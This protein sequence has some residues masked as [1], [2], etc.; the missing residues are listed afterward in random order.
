MPWWIS[1]LT[2]MFVQSEIPFYSFAP[3]RLSA[4]VGLCENKKRKNFWRPVILRGRQQSLQA[5]K[6]AGV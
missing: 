4:E 1:C 6:S 3:I 2:P 5:A